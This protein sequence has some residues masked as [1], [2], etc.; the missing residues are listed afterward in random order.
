[1]AKKQPTQRPRDAKGRFIKATPE[2]QQKAP[3][4]EAKKVD[5]VKSEAG[6]KRAS[7]GIRNERGQYVSKIFS[8]E[9][10][11]TLLATKRVDVSKVNSD[12][13]AKIDELLK[14]AKV[15]PLQVKKFY[16]K[17]KEIFEDLRTF[18][19]LKGTSKN[20]N[21]IEKAINDYKGEILINDGTKVKTVNKSEAKLLLTKFKSFLSSNIN[22]VDFTL[23]PMFDIDGKMTL[24]L[25]DPKKLLKDL[26]TYFGVTTTEE[27]D[28]FSGPEI[29]EALETILSD[30]YGEETDL[31]I[32]A[33]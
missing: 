13:S 21:Q 28:E 19:K 5:K 9:I 17:N 4:T 14:G 24:N 12:Q 30:M 26:K 15:T 27:L 18:G 33:S 8:N 11:K 29:M 32:Y 10:K 20:S 16:E 7:T 6:K 31:T 3:K 23:N 2:P 25:P 1:M 22:V